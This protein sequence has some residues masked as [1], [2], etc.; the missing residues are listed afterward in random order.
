[1]T[2]DRFTEF[3]EDDLVFPAA[4][5]PGGGERDLEA[6]SRLYRLP[7]ARFRSLG[8]HLD[9]TNWPERD[10]FMEL[11]RE[12]A[13][14]SPAPVQRRRPRRPLAPRP[15]RLFT[16]ARVSIVRRIGRPLA[17]KMR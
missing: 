12:I 13:V 6:E 2:T 5:A 10:R 17:S 9:Y 3:A 7:R 4:A 8:Q 16:T 11:D 14:E 15:N 1:M